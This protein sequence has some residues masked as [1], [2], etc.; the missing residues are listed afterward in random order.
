MR[1]KRNQKIPQ[2]L[3][4]FVHSINTVK[5]KNKKIAS[6]SRWS[7]KVNLCEN[8]HDKRDNGESRFD[9][10]KVENECNKVMR[11]VWIGGYCKDVVCHTNNGDGVEEMNEGND[12]ANSSNEGV[13]EVN[14]K[15]EEM[16]KKVNVDIQKNG[17]SDTN[18]ASNTA[19]MRLVNIVNSSRLDNKLVSMGFNEARYH[20]RR[21]WNRL[22][23]RDVIAENGV[24]YFRFQDEEGINR[25]INALASSIGKPVIMDEV[26]TKLCVTGVGRIGFARVLVEIDVEK[27]IKDKIE[28][29]YKIFGHIDIYCKVKSKNMI[30]AGIVKDFLP[31]VR[32]V[33]N[34]RFEGHTMYRVVQK[35]KALKRKL[36]QISWKNGNV[37]ERVEEL[38]KKVKESQNEVDM[39]PHDERVKEKSCMILK[40][41]HEAIQD[42][43]SLLC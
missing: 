27:G 20:I 36:K 26:T 14:E 9:G 43:N 11:T 13:K 35:M 32:S 24:F 30:D 2:N 31:T 6:K 29:M 3:E 34:K 15:G 10:K 25:G 41:Y 7:N 37:F 39:F 23:L 1:T 18:I 19:V 21:M 28:I 33:W 12:N 40:E 17:I 38:R 16:V 22:G 8:F 42:E 5:T 4:D